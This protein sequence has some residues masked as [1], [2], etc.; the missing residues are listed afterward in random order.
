M[1]GDKFEGSLGWTSSQIYYQKDCR[2]GKVDREGGE[3]FLN[4]NRYS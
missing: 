1:K 4:C 2:G 3:F